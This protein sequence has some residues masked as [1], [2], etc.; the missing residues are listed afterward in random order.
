MNSSKS[1]DIKLPR[2]VAIGW[3]I[4]T[5]VPS[6]MFNITNVFLMRFMTDLL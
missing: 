2:S 3:G 5:V 4:G 6:I 1:A